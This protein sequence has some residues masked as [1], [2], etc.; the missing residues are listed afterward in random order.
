MKSFLTLFNEAQ[1]L[2]QQGQQMQQQAQA[3]MQQGGE[4]LLGLIRQVFQQVGSDPTAYLT[5]VQD[6]LV[7]RPDM[8]RTAVTQVTTPEQMFHQ[9]GMWQKQGLLRPNTQP[10]I[11]PKPIP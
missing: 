7:K 10:A 4:K 3:N 5:A 2:Q 8:M 9:L 1:A 6:L 11:N